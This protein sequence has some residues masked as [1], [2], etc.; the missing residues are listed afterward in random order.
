MT[1][2]KKSS[3]QFAG[4]HDYISR[5][6]EFFEENYDSF[7]VMVRKISFFFHILY[8]QFFF[9][10][11]RRL[12]L[13]LK[14]RIK[15]P[16]YIH[17]NMVEIEVTTKCNMKCK[18]CDKSSGL[19]PSDEHMSLEQIRYFIRE[20][21]RNSKQWPFIVLTGGE[22]T[23]HP[24]I[25]E[26]VDLLI[27]YKSTFSPNTKISI[28]TN[29]A[30]QETKKILENLPP[31]IHQEFSDKTTVNL[32]HSGTYNVAPADVEKYQSR[33]TNFA[34]GCNI[35]SSSG[36][37][38]TRYGF[39]SC[40]AGASLDRVFGMDIGIKTIKGRTEKNFRN[41]MK[42]LCKYCG[43]F[44]DKQD[45]IYT[46]DDISP[47]WQKAYA[48]YAKKAPVLSLY[49]VKEIKDESTAHK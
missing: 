2:V 5:E 15:L 14:D 25:F 33:K 24:D 41:Q 28:S 13:F 1:K 35:P 20:S 43:H 48:N 23:L 18:Q 9:K 16:F 3:E 40:G 44:K 34:R 17:E 26:I 21:I 30:G 46:L 38:L 37:A 8:W 27:Q 22:P 39:Y 19:A 42:A 45:E 29:G 31:I 36:T 7:N 4:R 32:A 6:L 11:Y 49:G 47:I 12:D 10:L